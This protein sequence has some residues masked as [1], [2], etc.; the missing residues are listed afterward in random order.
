MCIQFYSYVHMSCRFGLCS[1][2]GG[3]DDDDDGGDGDACDD[4]DGDGDGY[5]D[6]DGDGDGDCDDNHDD[7][8]GDCDDDHD[9]GDGDGDEKTVHGDSQR[10]WPLLRNT[11]V[12]LAEVSTLKVCEQETMRALFVQSYI[13]IDRFTLMVHGE[14]TSRIELHSQ[15]RGRSITIQQLG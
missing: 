5:E 12:A 3:D 8:D 14:Y 7:C 10:M 2:G 4:G 11:C 15:L 6:D 1:G 13:Q 9:D